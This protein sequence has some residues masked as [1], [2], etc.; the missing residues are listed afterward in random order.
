MSD[1]QN[2]AAKTRKT[3]RSLKKAVTPAEF[4]GPL[5]FKTSFMIF[6]D[7]RRDGITKKVRA[8]LKPDEKFNVSMVAKEL[9]EAWRAIDPADKKKY[10]D[11]A[12]ASKA[13]YDAALEKWKL[14]ADYKLFVKA[15]ALHNK[16]RADKQATLKAKESGM[17]RQPMT[18]YFLY[19]NEIR[20]AVRGELV[21][22]GE[23]YN[24]KS[25][26]AITKA[27]WDALG[28]EGQKPYKAKFEAAKIQYAEDM[29]AWNDS[30]AGKE[31][32]KAKATN[33]K[34]KANNEKVGKPA[35][36]VKK[37]AETAPEESVEESGD[38]E[39]SVEL[40]ADE[41]EE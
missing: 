21:A 31:F 15:N 1:I 19:A 16:K 39:S 17:P 40:S 30:D 6:G 34:R 2:V 29:K 23:T 25:G 36:K 33:A 5:R 14:S 26:A 8:G 38:G 28:E 11:M 3:K 13:T 27:K 41:A 12:K 4:N 20:E 37:D 22:K 24:I 7:D 35:K 18:G 10:E 9:G 32:A